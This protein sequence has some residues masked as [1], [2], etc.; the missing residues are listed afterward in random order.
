MFT[1]HRLKFGEKSRFQLS[2]T[3]SAGRSYVPRHSA[4]P[5][6][7]PFAAPAAG[8]VERRFSEAETLILDLR[9]AGCS[10]TELIPA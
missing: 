10:A 2:G 9:P 8:G 6:P 5:R 1:S 4:E 3:P 7:I